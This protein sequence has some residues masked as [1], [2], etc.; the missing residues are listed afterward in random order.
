MLEDLREICS[1]TKDCRVQQG[2]D[3]DDDHMTDLR[4]HYVGL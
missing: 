2:P 4:G 1:H 3:L